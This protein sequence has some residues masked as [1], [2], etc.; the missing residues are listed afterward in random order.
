M[1]PENS[2]ITNYLMLYQ[3]IIFSDYDDGTDYVVCLYDTEE[4]D[5]L[6][7]V[8]NNDNGVARMFNM[9]KMAVQKD[10]GSGMLIKGR[11]RTERFICDTTTTKAE[12]YK[13]IM[14]E[15]TAKEMRYIRK[16][17]GY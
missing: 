6:V 10:R 14:Q 9:T 12:Y 13:I 4:N 15:K 7:A 8:F 17:M 16:I 3:A 11:F 1:I 2:L 5:R